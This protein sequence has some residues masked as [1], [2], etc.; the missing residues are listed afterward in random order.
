MKLE[1]IHHITAITGDAQRNVDFY[2]GTLGLRMVKKTVNQ[3]APTVYHLFYADEQGSPGADLTFFEFRGAPPGRAGAGM[4]HRIVWRVGS[5]EALD[6]WAERLGAAGVESERVGRLAALRR[7]GGARPRAR[8]RRDARRAAD[9]R[10]P[11]GPARGGAPGLPRGAG[12]R[13]RAQAQRGDSSRGAGLQRPTAPSGRRAAASAA[14]SGSTTR[15]RRARDA[16]RR[17]RPSHRLG[18]ADGRARGMARPRDRGGARPTPVIDRF[19]FR[20]IYFREPS[21]VL[22]EIATLGPG[23][24]R[25][26]GSRAPGREADPAAVPRGPPRGDRGGAGAGHEPAPGGGEMSAGLRL[27]AGAGR[28]AADGPGRPAQARPGDEALDAYSATVTTV[29]GRLAP[30][31]ASLAMCDRRGGARF[32]QE[33]A[34][35]WSSPTTATC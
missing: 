12:I 7:P 25:G 4:V 15:P 33:P 34:A 22:F 18:I 6:F 23:L 1:G 29:A 24:R 32:R 3:D 2:A 20:S 9:R 26:R 8:G 27:V 11:G 19:W 13:G 21:G 30:A 5:D 17:H 16:G 14:G 31:V 35:P 28:A 10:P